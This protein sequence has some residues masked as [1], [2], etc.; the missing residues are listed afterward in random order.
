MHNGVIQKAQILV[1][2]HSVCRNSKSHNTHR[3]VKEDDHA[4]LCKAVG[5]NVV[6]VSTNGLDHVNR[7]QPDKGIP[8]NFRG[9]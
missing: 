2:G 7:I 9:T 4:F 6:H 8:G 1:S 5:R 3:Q